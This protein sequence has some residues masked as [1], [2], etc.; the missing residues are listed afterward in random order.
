MRRG[1][2]G[3]T[4]WWV[5]SALAATLTTWT[6]TAA[7]AQAP[8]RDPNVLR[9]RFGGGLNPSLTFFELGGDGHLQEKMALGLSLR[10][11]YAYRLTR[12]FELGADFAYWYLPR[13]GRIAYGVFMPAL[14]LRPYLPLGE[15]DAVEIGLDL[16]AGGAIIGVMPDVGTWTGWGAS[17]GP[18]VRA[19]L[20]PSCALQFGVEISIGHGHNSSP[21][22]SWYQNESGWFGALGLW[23]AL[24]ARF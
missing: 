20:W 3:T 8:R 18:D 1:S 13:E 15:G 24:M 11:G 12:G 10:L 19:W 6:A 21:D 7:Q 17:G 5:A 2:T 23:L 22:P 16:H 14:A 4:P 9:H